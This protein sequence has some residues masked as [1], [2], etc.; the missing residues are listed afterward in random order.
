MNKP[1]ASLLA[2]ILLFVLLVI[3]RIPGVDLAVSP[4]EP[5]WLA[6]SANFY[7]AVASGDWA[8]TYQV[9]HP[10]VM[11]MYS[12]M[13]SFLLQFPG[14]ATSAP[15]PFAWDSSDIEGWLAEN[16]AVSPLSLLIGGRWAVI[17]VTALIL[18][19]KPSNA[20]AGVEPVSYTHL[21]LPTS[22]LV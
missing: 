18:V 19:L 16:S 11:I 1:F 10:G 12:G 3:P 9:E 14:L 7:R 15:A 22:D 13:T 6:R 4:D 21:T 20:C 8:G 17:L 2:G 5:K